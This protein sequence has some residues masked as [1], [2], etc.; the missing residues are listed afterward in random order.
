MG[1]FPRIVFTIFIVGFF[2]I[3][4]INTNAVAT[5]ATANFAGMQFNNSD[6]D[7]IIAQTGMNH[8]SLLITFLDLALAASVVGLW[9]GHLKEFFQNA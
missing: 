9:W 1:L 6:S 5:I 8:I 7:A 3:L 2:V 4:N